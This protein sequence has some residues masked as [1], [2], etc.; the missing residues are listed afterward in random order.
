MAS[1]MFSDTWNG[2]QRTHGNYHVETCYRVCHDPDTY[3]DPQGICVRGFSIYT[4]TKSALDALLPA[5]VTIQINSGRTYSYYTGD[6]IRTNQYSPSGVLMRYAVV[7]SS[8]DEIQFP[9]GSGTF[10]IHVT[11]T[12]AN[13]DIFTFNETGYRPISNSITPPE[14]MVTGRIYDFTLGR[15]AMAGAMFSNNAILRLSPQANSQVNMGLLDYGYVNSTT[16][17]SDATSAFSTIQFAVANPG[18]G[19]SA[20]IV[21]V[22]FQT[23]YMSADF[24]NGILITDCTTQTQMTVRDGV[25][26]ELKPVLT[27]ALVALTGTYNYG[28]SA[29]PSYVHRMSTL[30]LTPNAQFKYG[31]SLAYITCDNKTSLTTYVTTNAVGIEPGTSYTRPDTGATVTAG[32]QTVGC[33]HISVLGSKWGISSDVVTKTYNV[34]WYLT[35]RINSF[36]VHRASRSSS[37]TSYSQG[38]YYYKKDDFGTY[39]IAEYSISFASIGNSNNKA[40]VLQ[41]GSYTRQ[42]TVSSN[43]VSGYYIFSA[44]ET[45]MNV[46]IELTDNFFPYGV[47]A[48]TRLSTAG[49]LIDYLAGGKG[50]AIGKT[51]TQQ[52]AL[53]IAR[54]WKLLFYNADVGAYNNDTSSIDL[55]SWMHNIDSR[56]TQLENS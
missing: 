31:D 41:Y 16:K 34:Y 36:S 43:T 23:R 30:T 1:V 39:C 54:D 25:D 48:T 37:S 4:S 18:V 55:V 2:I 28:T 27:S 11:I 56:L 29:S 15:S 40:A 51:A 10:T 50:M 3:A 12:T 42:L 7:I 24:N 13:N 46:S 35:P 33:V 9:S 17:V 32:E 20:W 14:S 44:G 38:G 19:T 52:K 21:D 6:T 45:A 53:D 5:T 47:T 26:T 8:L 22:V 49:V